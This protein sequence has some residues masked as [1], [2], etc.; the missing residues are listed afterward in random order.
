M[1]NKGLR[2]KEQ[3]RYLPVQVRLVFVYVDVVERI[4]ADPCVERKPILV[5][6]FSYRRQS[7]CLLG[8]GVGGIK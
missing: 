2:V 1:K 3:H 4:H 6:P 8:G 5:R 7:Y